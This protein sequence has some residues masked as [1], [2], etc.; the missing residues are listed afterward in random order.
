MG[1]GEKEMRTYHL[2]GLTSI[3]A[4]TIGLA[5]SSISYA[6]DTVAEDAAAEEIVVSGIRGAQQAAINVKRNA[7]SVVDAI[8]A[9]D[10]GKLPDA[11]IADSL[12]RIPGVQIRREAGEGGAVN[13]RGLPQ[14]VTQLNGESFIGAGS[15]TSVQPN[16]TDIPSQLFAGA[17]VVKSPT[18]SM[19]DA[20]ITGTINL[21]TRRPF[22]L[23][24][25]LTATI[26]AEGTY[27]NVT[28][29]IDPQANGLIS[30]HNDSVGIL[31]SAS[32]SDVTLANNYNG[33]D[34]RTVQQLVNETAPWPVNQGLVGTNTGDQNRDGDLLDRYVAYRGYTAYNQETQR[35]R[36]GL[37]AS[38]QLAF[39]DA[40][41]LTGDAFYTDQRQWD[42]IAGFSA[43]EKGGVR[44]WRWFTPINS[45]DAG[46]ANGLQ[47]YSSALLD[48]RRLRSYS[49]VQRSESRAYNFNG[50]LKYDNDGK[51]TG[52]VRAIYSKARQNN[53]NSY[54]DIDL[55]SGQQWGVANPYYPGGNRLTNP[56]GYS[57]FPQVT[58][59][60][61]GGALNFEGLPA[62]AMD[63]LAG[64]SFGAFTSEN[65][66]D[67]DANLKVFRADGRYEFSENVSLSVGGRYGDRTAE[68]FAYE[69]AAPAYGTSCLVR[70]KATDVVLNSPACPVGDAGGFYTALQPRLLSTF[71]DQ[72]IRVKKFGN[73]TGV[74]TNGIY[75]LNPHVMDDP[76]AFQN[77]VYPGNVRNKNPGASYKVGME[78]LSGF[79][80]LDFNGD[81]GIPF[82]GNVG[83]RVIQTNL[84]I[85]QNI[86][87]ANQVYNLNALDIGDLVTSRK[88]TDILPAANLR[89]D[90]AENLVIRLA[91]AKA[92]TPLDLVQWGGGLTPTY[93]INQGTGIFEI[94]AAR[95]SGNPNLDPWRSSNFDFSAE[96]YF[97]RTSLLS[98]GLFYIKVDSFIAAGSVPQSLPDQDG[99]IRR[100]TNVATSVQ[101][102]G[103]TLK[104]A[105]LGLKVAFDF[106]PGFFQDFGIDANYT[107]SPSD[108]DFVD[109]DNN[110]LPFQ[111]NSKHQT[112]F[113][114]WYQGE[115]LQAR[116]AHNYRSKRVAG[117]G[118]GA[119]GLTSYQEPTS[120]IDA[121]VSYDFT[122]KFT[123]T[124]QASNI[125]KESENYYIQYPEQPFYQSGYERRL[126]AGV[127][128]RF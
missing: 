122:E 81:L 74:P 29:S 63:N 91:Y 35:K 3:A 59:S 108:S 42:R 54:A 83:V 119:P 116:V 62:A 101:G 92:M 66:F 125:T 128:Y 73:V 6:Q 38:V 39:S 40:V 71:G 27:G 61:R 2:H 24:S 46:P 75:T 15:I 36:L 127:R 56:Q 10:I 26:A 22:D 5:N 96:W 90:P 58:V 47:A 76:L 111:D 17:E 28:K 104:G 107:F 25:G 69:L 68:N 21:K 16:F 65:N 50:E 86:I 60:T 82:A 13:V 95:S 34:L 79:A 77:S 94:T 53:I 43:A 31:L 102:N 12:Q 106:L 44:G 124:F 18:A 87:G 7:S 80:Q 51:F 1:R 37:N 126:L 67:R 88:Y 49:S 48:V 121:S 4:M 114:L 72:V 14:V 115:K 8:S 120:F 97:G 85:V 41:T 30:W 117:F 89:I 118:V 57:G 84:N 33:A 45:I 103:G 52:T 32:Y 70:F 110:K 112:N 93:N 100:V 113:V 105:E 98:L 19:L 55:A 11:T 23:K 64:Y 20:G 78:Q 9:E 99:V 123:L 109:I